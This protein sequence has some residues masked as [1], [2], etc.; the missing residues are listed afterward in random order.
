MVFISRNVNIKEE[1]SKESSSKY[2]KYKYTLS[3]CKTFHEEVLLTLEVLKK[4]QNVDLYDG[5]TYPG[6]WLNTD[7]KNID[8]IFGNKNQKNSQDS[9]N[10]NNTIPENLINFFEN[11]KK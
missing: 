7:N 3:N 4:E 6:M 9:N 5:T 2:R 11:D 8:K 10:V 1:D